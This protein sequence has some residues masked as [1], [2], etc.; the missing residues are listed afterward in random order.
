ME[1]PSCQN[2]MEY[3]D[4]A[5]L[6]SYDYITGHEQTE[7]PAYFYCEECDYIDAEE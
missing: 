6:D 3:I 7:L 5:V 2:N 1:C 4:D